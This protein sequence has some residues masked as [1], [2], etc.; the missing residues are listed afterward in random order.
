MKLKS[1]I[2]LTSFLLLLT[3]CNKIFVRNN[4]TSQENKEIQMSNMNSE[5][6]LSFV[7]ESLKWIIKDE[8]TE[9]FIN[10]VRDYNDSISTNLL[11]ADFSNNLHSDYDIGEIIKERDKI[12]HEYLNTNCRINTFLLLKDSISLKKNVDI[13]DSMLFMDIDII[14]KSKLFNEDETK[15]FKKLFS[16]VKTIKSKNPKKQAKIMSDFLSNFNFPKNVKMIS[17]VLHDNLDGDYLFIGHVGVLIPNEK[18]YLFLEKISFEEP[19]QALKFSNKESCYKY[20]KEKYKDYK[21][22][23]VAP[24]FIMENNKYVE[25]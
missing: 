10:L 4:S 8:N 22:P 2:I 19:Y 17:V 13:D 18:G 20:L 7:K 3:A 24:P 11:S 23:N 21:D 25:I 9:N 6:T 12:N 1:L 16:R 15:K 5:K 14:E